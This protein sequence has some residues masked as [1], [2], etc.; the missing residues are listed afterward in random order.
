LDRAAARSK[1]GRRRE[2]KSGLKTQKEGE[3]AMNKLLVRV[4]EQTYVAPTKASVRGYL[5]KE[6]PAAVRATIRPSTRLS[7]LLLIEDDPLD[8][9][10]TLHFLTES[11]AL[12]HVD[13]HDWRCRLQ[14]GTGGVVPAE[15][16]AAPTGQAHGNKDSQDR[17]RVRGHSRTHLRPATPVPTH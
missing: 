5:T 7:D 13:P 4:E 17:L 2:T 6:W 1:Q 16:V 10:L 14:K 12:R 9:G 11:G 8:A 15:P 3:A